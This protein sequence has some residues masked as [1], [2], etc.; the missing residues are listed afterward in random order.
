MKDSAILSSKLIFLILAL[1][2]KPQQ[3]ICSRICLSL[4]IINSKV[5]TRELLGLMDLSGAQALCIHELTKV[6][7]VCKDENFMLAAFPI[8]TPCLEGFDDSQKLTVVGL[9]SYLC[10]NHFPRKE[11]YWVPLAQIGLNDYP[12]RT[13]SGS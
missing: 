3:S 1:L 10:R 8:V 12:I 6:I 9:I 7:M 13:S 11:C 5:I 2:R 4:A